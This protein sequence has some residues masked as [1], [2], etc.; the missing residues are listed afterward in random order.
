MALTVPSTTTPLKVFNGIRRTPEGMLYLT[1]TTSDIQYSNYFE[2][3]K[4]D[5]V[6]KDG[7]DYVE[8]RLEIYNVQYF[9]GDG[10][11]LTFTLNATG[12]TAEGIA[13]FIDGTRKIAYEDYSVSAT[14][15]TFVL[16]PSNAAVITVGAINKRYRNNDSDRYQQFVFD[17]NST[18]TYLINSSGDL[19]KRL[20]N[21]GGQTSTSDDFDTFEGTATVNTTTWQSAV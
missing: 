21:A 5:S 4:S 16:K 8:E 12:M 19:V 11:T 10:S 15:L 18:A 6:P 9:T 2:P 1:S 3:G 14:T 13:V 7:T 17:V 20:N